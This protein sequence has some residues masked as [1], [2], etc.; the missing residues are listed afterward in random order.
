ME[1]Y[2]YILDC[3]GRYY[4]GITTDLR[5]RL[6]EHRKGSSR[7]AKFTR[8]AR[9]QALVYSVGI[10]E[11]GLALRAEARLKRLRRPRKAQVICDA[12]ARE[13]LLGMLGLGDSQSETVEVS[14]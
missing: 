4:T 1:W 8:A 2:L 11:R 5:R 14:P 13:R 6:E 10:G 9:S 3:D 7:G 12:P